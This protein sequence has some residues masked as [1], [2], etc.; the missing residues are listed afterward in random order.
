MSFICVATPVTPALK[1]SIPAAASE[2]VTIMAASATS[3]RPIDAAAAMKGTN[4][5]RAAADSA[6][7]PAV[8]AKDAPRAANIWTFSRARPAAAGAANCAI[9]GSCPTKVDIASTISAIPA[10]TIR[11]AA[12]SARR[13]TAPTVAAEPTNRITTAIAVAAPTMPKNT[14]MAAGP[15]SASEMAAFAIML[16]PAATIK[17]A[18]PSATSIRAVPAM[19]ANEEPAEAA[20]DAA[21]P[22][23][24]AKLEKWLPS[25]ERLLPMVWAAPMNFETNR[26]TGPTAAAISATLMMRSCVSGLR[27]RHFSVIVSMMGMTVSMAIEIAGPKASTSS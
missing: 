9:I 26:M 5:T 12:P 14:A 21:C 8:I 27:L 16:M 3:A 24:L 4:A 18:A 6:K 20:P 13:P 1:R 23:L 2:A 11:T 17:T 19:F 7:S 15:A 10:E 22:A 25:D